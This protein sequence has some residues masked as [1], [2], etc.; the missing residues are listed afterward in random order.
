MTP[1]LRSLEDSRKI[2]GSKAN[3]VRSSY[4][5]QKDS[6]ASK[7]FYSWLEMCYNTY[8]E[9]AETLVDKDIRMSL[10]DQALTFQK[11]KKYLDRQAS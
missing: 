11:V 9:S 8:M 3:A 10:V 7:D 1:R 5:A 2:D 6:L 4:K